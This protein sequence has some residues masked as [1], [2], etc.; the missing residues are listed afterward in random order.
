MRL[1]MRIRQSDALGAAPGQWLVELYDEHR[2]VSVVLGV[3]EERQEALEYAADIGATLD[4]VF[5]IKELGHEV[6]VYL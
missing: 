2:G 4:E 5:C 6:M 1:Y 3:A